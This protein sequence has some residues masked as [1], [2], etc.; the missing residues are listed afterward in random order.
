MH[1]RRNVTGHLPEPYRESVD[2][3]MANA[4]A[5]SSCADAKAALEKLHRELLEL[6]PSA[7]RS[8]EEGREET[9]TV[10]PAR[11]LDDLLRCTLATTHKTRSSRP[12]RWWT[13]S[14]AG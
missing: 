2:R 4:Y 14:A 5:M 7:A 10:L 12:S 3:K 6:N 13:A 9:L 8:L 11:P 1:K